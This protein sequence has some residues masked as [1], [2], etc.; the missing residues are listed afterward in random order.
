MKLK[1]IPDTSGKTC[2]CGSW[3]DHWKKFSNQSMPTY[4]PVGGC[5]EKVEVGAHVKKDGE[6]GVYI[7][8]LCKKHNAETG[9]F[10]VPDYTAL[11]SAD[12]SLTC[13]KK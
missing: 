2:T 4:C 9:T 12:V 3:L 11:A 7:V 10:E 8:P 5:L 1:N 13:G 6:K